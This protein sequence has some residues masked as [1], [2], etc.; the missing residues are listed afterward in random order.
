M[1]AKTTETFG[2]LDIDAGIVN[3]EKI[4]RKM[5][6]V[7][8]VSL[9]VYVMQ[10]KS[11]QLVTPFWPCM[12]ITVKTL[13]RGSTHWGQYYKSSCYILYREVDFFF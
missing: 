1:F 12:V 3:G 2:G 5:F 11:D 13:N 7:N 8:V 6:E 10:Y 9:L 4:W